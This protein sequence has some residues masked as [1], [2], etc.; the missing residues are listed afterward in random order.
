MPTIYNFPIKQTPTQMGVSMLAI[1]LSLHASCTSLENPCVA[2]RAV[3]SGVCV[4]QMWSVVGVHR[5]YR[6]LSGAEYDACIAASCMS[7]RCHRR[8][9]HHRI[10]ASTT[11]H[12]CS[13]RS[14]LRPPSRY[15]SVWCYLSTYTS[16]GASEWVSFACVACLAYAA[17]SRDYCGHLVVVQFCAS[18]SCR[19]SALRHTI[20]GQWVDTLL[21]Y[22]MYKVY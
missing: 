5:V 4:A 3:S 17:R 18:S 6:S 21:H 10:H 15:H 9:H 8:H 20:H 12:R 1:P 16:C 13:H 7:C 11:L 19:S 22:Y 2:M 14:L